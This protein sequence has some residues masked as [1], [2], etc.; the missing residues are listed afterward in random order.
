MQETIQRKNGRKADEL[1]PIRVTYD[2]YGY[3]TASV[4]L[5]IGNTKV[6]S[7]VSLQN[8][9]PPFLKH[10]K[11][12]WLTAEYAMLPAATAVRTQR[13]SS[14][15]QRNSRSVEISRL[16]GRCLRS[17]VDLT[18]IGEQTIV[19]DCDVLQADG[20]TRTASIT[21]ASLALACAAR[22]WVA[23]G[24]VPAT[25]MPEPIAAISVGVING[26]VSL[27]IDY[28]EDNSTQADFNFVLTQ[29]GSII[30]IQGT[31]EKMAVSWQDFATMSS[32]ALHGTN[33]LFNLFDEQQV[34]LKRMQQQP[35]I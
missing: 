17:A 8:S 14:G 6:L 1:R 2:V 33:Q 21:A 27:D 12:G 31:A 18:I 35:H 5:E 9:V 32:L 13:E 19:I 25:F 20:G 11:T 16:I 23:A 10:K 3:A 28:A 29:S 22:R 7:S 34:M 26:Q 4:L 24:Q 15:N 30:E